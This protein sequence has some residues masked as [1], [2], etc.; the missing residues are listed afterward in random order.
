MGGAR[1]KES[2]LLRSLKKREKGIGGKGKLT[3][4]IIDRLENYYR[5]V[6]QMQDSP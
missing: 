3:N 6:N 5:T 1:S 2:R 4:S